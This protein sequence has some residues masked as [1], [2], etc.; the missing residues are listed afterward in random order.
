MLGKVADLV[1]NKE[2]FIFN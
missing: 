1:I 2:E